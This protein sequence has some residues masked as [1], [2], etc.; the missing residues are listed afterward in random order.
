M[1]AGACVIRP[2]W[3]VAR[4]SVFLCT[5]CPPVLIFDRLGLAARGPVSGKEPKLTPIDTLGRVPRGA[6]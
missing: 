6:R 4:A 2:S 3:I 1:A 5:D